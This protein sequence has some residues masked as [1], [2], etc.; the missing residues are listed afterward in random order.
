VVESAVAC[1]AL[2]SIHGVTNNDRMVIPG[3]V[4]NGVVV[5]NGGLLLPEGTE[6]SVSYPV[7][8]GGHPSRSRE[9]VQLP[10]IRSARPGS[11]QITAERVAELLEE[12]V[13]A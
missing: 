11:R 3:R 4:H 8:P 5:V 9:R 2:D 7:S 13:S 6:V 12:D 1:F 10:L